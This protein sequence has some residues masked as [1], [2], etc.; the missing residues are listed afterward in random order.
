MTTQ[1]LHDSGI[2][3]FFPCSGLTRNCSRHE[4]RQH[5]SIRNQNNH[6]RGTRLSRCRAASLSSATSGAPLAVAL[7]PRFLAYWSAGPAPRA[8][9]PPDQQHPDPAPNPLS[10]KKCFRPDFFPF[11]ILGLSEALRRPLPCSVLLLSR[12]SGDEVHRCPGSVR[13]IE[14]AR[15]VRPGECRQTTGSWP[16]LLPPRSPRHMMSGRRPRLMAC[17]SSMVRPPEARGGI[18]RLRPEGCPFQSAGRRRVR[19]SSGENARP[20]EA[21]RGGQR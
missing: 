17:L 4:M 2:L 16:W 6:R 12:R 10:R 8:R 11:F 7:S 9:C 14:K 15:A 13:S 18:G 19:G 20:R 1:I 5:T 21:R 3:H